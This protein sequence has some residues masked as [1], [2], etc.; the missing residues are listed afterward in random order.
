M[1]FGKFGIPN[2]PIGKKS[3]FV[4]KIG[5]N[6]QKKVALIL[7]KIGSGGSNNINLFKFG[8]FQIPIFPIGKKYNL[9]FSRSDKFTKDFQYKIF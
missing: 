7:L 3:T 2:V 4:P 6:F 9:S 5:V 1:K 8:T